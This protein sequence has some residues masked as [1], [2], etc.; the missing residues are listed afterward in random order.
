VGTEARR[1]EA[2]EANDARLE[3]LRPVGTPG[4]FLPQ[5]QISIGNRA[6]ANA[7]GRER[8]HSWVEIG[9]LAK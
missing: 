2:E 3:S 6:I 7:K 5:R 8:E 4:R 1:V 9:R